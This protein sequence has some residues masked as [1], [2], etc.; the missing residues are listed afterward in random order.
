MK[1]KV[2]IIAPRFYGIDEAIGKAFEK[3]G[4]EVKLV[5]SRT[6]LSLLEKLA[7]RM[8][9]V[10]PPLS[11][12]ADLIIKLFLLQEN[13]YFLKVTKQFRPDLLFVIKGESILP[14]MLKKLKVQAGATV[15]YIWDDPF[16]SYAGTYSDK[17]RRTNFEKGLRQYDYIFVYDRFYVEKIRERGAER[18]AYLPLAASPSQYGPVEINPKDQIKYS[19]DICF[20][21]VP[22]PNR[23]EILDSLKKYKLGVFGDGWESYFFQKGQPLP[24]YFKG[25]AQ[26]AEVVKL[27]LCSKIV[28]NIHDPEARE[29]LNTRTF[30]VLSCGAF[31]LVDHKKAV[32]EHFNVQEEIVVY[33]NAEEL[34]DLVAYYLEHPAERKALVEKG[35]K[36]VLAR[37]TWLNRMT[38]AVSLLRENQLLA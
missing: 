1:P 27:Y 32:E 19:Y 8:A 20:V 34:Q 33:R 7:K 36:K 15:C 21:G 37:H 10:L 18:V 3:Q 38:E 11:Y 12:F 13:R 35:R 31:E 14:E 24:P 23:V 30:D 28:L 9:K 29:G 5:T 6:R 22:Y 16:Y 26:G 4:F 17:Y 25:R 2:L